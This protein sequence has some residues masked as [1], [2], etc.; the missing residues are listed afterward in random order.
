MERLLLQILEQYFAIALINTFML[1][2]GLI[3]AFFWHT[4]TWTL[5]DNARSSFFLLVLLLDFPPWC[6]LLI[7]PGSMCVL[8]CSALIPVWCW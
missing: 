3:W 5:V 2:F 4:I 6:L 7:L 1:S 8:G